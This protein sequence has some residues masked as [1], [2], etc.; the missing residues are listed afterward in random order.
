MR[1]CCFAW[2]ISTSCSIDDAKTASRVLGLT[3]TSRDKG[4]NPIPMA[5]FP[6]HQLESYLAK[7]IAARP[8]GRGLRAGRRPEAG[9][10][11]GQARSDAR[12]H[13][14]HADRRRAARPAREQL[15]GGRRAAGAQEQRRRPRRARLGR[16]F[17]RPLFRRDRAAAR[18]WPTSWPGSARPSAWSPKMRSSPLRPAAPRHDA[19]AAARRGPSASKRPSPRCKSTFRR[20]RSTALASTTATRP[21]MR[22]AGAVLDYLRETQKTSLDH[23][24]R[25]TPYRAGETAGNRRSDAPQP[26]D[27]PHAPR[28]QR[29]RAR[30]WR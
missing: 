9:Q 26:G 3:L 16:A 28:R 22:A 25:L 13:A 6:Y 12:R 15:P 21:A 29:A 18:D 27:D 2:A 14:R 8:A 4:E 24:D 20:P 11:A 30:C 19:H 17:D 1:C 7:L 5:G 23:I 10:G